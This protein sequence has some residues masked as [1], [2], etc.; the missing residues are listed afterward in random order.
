MQSALVRFASNTDRIWIVAAGKAAVAM[1][2]GAAACAGDRVVGGVVVAPG[3]ADVPAPLEFCSAEHPQPD[4]G[5][6]RAGRRALDVARAVPESDLLLVL[7]SGGASSLL[8]VPA[9]GL[10]LDDKRK[11]TGLLLKSGADIY[12]LNTVRKHLS[13]VKGGRLAAA[14]RARCLA[15]VLSDVVG[16]DLSV[17]ASGPTV[18]DA[19]TFADALRVLDESGGR[20]AFPPAVVGHLEAGAEAE[21]STA[22]PTDAVGALA[23]TTTVLI[24]GRRNAMQGAR[25]EA[26]RRGYA[27]RVIDDPVL[28]EAR[29]AGPRFVRM[30][31]PQ[32]ARN[33]KQPTCTIA[34]GET[35]VR[36]SGNGRGGRNQELALAALPTLA[37]I[38]R[39][40]VLV[41]VGTDG[42]DG[43]TDAAGAI[44]DS[45]SLARSID[46]HLTYEDYLNN[47]DA[48]SFFLALNDLVLTGPTGTNV[49]DLQ[50]FLLA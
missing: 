3:H 31:A 37:E 45:D 36:V 49:G 16:D 1:A 5:S 12:A 17:I 50:V 43:P 33:S 44:A 32:E 24:G 2:R 30:A 10:T 22:N 18:P 21:R 8:A 23:H 35:T 14:T 34:S 20:A 6:E 13:A 27:V 28:G 39:A 41:S 46:C 47:N 9:A 40:A 25:A 4:A 26:E 7:V 19:S 11:T 48:Y 15:L 38:G 29:Q 42:I